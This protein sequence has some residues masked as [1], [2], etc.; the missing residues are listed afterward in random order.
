MEQ[1]LG[2]CPGVRGVLVFGLGREGCGILVEVEGEPSADFGA[3]LDKAN[4]LAD[5]D[6]REMV[7]FISPGELVRMDKGSIAR[8][9]S[10][11][12]WEKEIV[13]SYEDV[14]QEEE[15]IMDA[16]AGVWVAHVLKEV[17]GH[18]IPERRTF[19]SVEWTRYRLRGYGEGSDVR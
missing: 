17:L 7:V 13:K 14:E 12:K 10:W 3:F 15:P 18:V 1:A 9:A 5:K 2:E 19:S 8:K 4:E 6:A 11:E 16:D